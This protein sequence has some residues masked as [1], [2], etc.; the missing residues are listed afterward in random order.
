MA[1]GRGGGGEGQDSLARKATEA[2]SILAWRC[3]SG[4]R[5]WM[6]CQGGRRGGVAQALANGNGREGRGVA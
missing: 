4:D 6:K 3:F 5:R 1:R 2:A